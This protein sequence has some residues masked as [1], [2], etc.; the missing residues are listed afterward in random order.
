MAGRSTQSLDVMRAIAAILP[1]AF[2]TTGCTE[3]RDAYAKVHLPPAQL[4]GSYQSSQKPHEVL[5]AL[6]DA[7]RK[8]TVVEDSKGPA[9]PD[10]RPRFDFL[11][12]EVEDQ[13]YCG[14]RGTLRLTFF[15]D[16]LNSTIF[17]PADVRACITALGQAPTGLER[18]RLIAANTLLMSS[19]D[20]KGRPYVAWHDQ[21]MNEE[22]DRWVSKYS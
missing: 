8:Y 20:Y 19:T 22:Q 11:V 21:R 6:R 2:V 14:Q 9:P 7:K 12:L 10:R 15:N 16:R 18:G 3:A 4:V 1:F 5:N 13:E 17:Y